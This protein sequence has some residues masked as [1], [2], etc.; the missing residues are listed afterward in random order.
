MGLG[1]SG[2]AAARLLLR[3]GVLVVGT[4]LKPKEEL[5]SEVDGLERAG[6]KMLLGANPIDIVK[7]VDCLIVSPGVPESSNLVREARRRNIPVIGEI[8]FAYLFLEDHRIVAVTG[9]NG[10]TTTTALIGEIL[11]EDGRSVWV[12]GNMAPGEPLTDIALHAKSGDFIVAEV[13][14]FQLESIERFRPQVGV[15]TNITP[16][17]LD[18]HHDFV[19][20]IRLKAR[21]FENQTESDWAVLNADDENVSSATQGIRSKKTWFS[22]RGIPSPGVG[23]EGHEIGRAHV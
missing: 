16:D 17:H 1:R 10:K 23:L 6:M 13:S 12:G 5:G 14:T 3:E 18:R 20:Y 22:R 9:T 21:L 2:Q 8:E 4:D 11:K 15:L 7:T 19:S